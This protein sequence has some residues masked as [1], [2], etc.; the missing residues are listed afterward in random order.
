MEFLMAWTG[1]ELAL[2]RDLA[3]WQALMEKVSDIAGEWRM[4]LLIR[5]RIITVSLF[6]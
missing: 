1:G 6:P 3:C 5:I 4:P 2:A